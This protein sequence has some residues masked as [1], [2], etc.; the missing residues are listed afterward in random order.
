MNKAIKIFMNY[1]VTNK[2]LCLEKK[3][4]FL[5]ILCKYLSYPFQVT[6]NCGADVSRV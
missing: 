5:L 2:Y 1:P 6:L 4:Y 3:H